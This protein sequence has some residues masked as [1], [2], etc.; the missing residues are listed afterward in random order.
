LMSVLYL[1]LKF[2]SVPLVMAK[3]QLCRYHGSDVSCSL[4]AFPPGALTCLP[5]RRADPQDW[6]L[7]LARRAAGLALGTETRGHFCCGS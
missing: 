4:E 6:G 7:C 3:R 1:T 5:G 2:A